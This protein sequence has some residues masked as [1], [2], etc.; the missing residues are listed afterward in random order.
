LSIVI[1]Y[2]LKTFCIPH[3][4]SQFGLNAGQGIE[5]LAANQFSRTFSLSN[6]TSLWQK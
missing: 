5:C 2:M 4:I 6:T 1:Y 3:L